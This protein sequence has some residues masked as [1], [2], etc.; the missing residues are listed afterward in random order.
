MLKAPRC[1]AFI[2]AG[3]LVDWRSQPQRKGEKREFRRDNI[4]RK[5]SQLIFNAVQ[6]TD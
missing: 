6:E 4:F 2:F 1:G 3:L 5:G